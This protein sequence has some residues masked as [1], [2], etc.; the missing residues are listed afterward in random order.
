MPP[1]SL[2][3]PATSSP[4][5]GPPARLGILASGSGS[6]FAA[7]QQAI[8]AQQLNAEIRC[9]LYNIADAH[10]AKRARAHNIPAIFIDHKAYKTRLAFDTA[11][12]QQL[13]QHD[14]EWLL[15]AGW[16]RRLTTTFID[17]YPN[18]IL[19]IHPS[20]LPSFPGLHAVEQ[21]LA[22][23][24]TISGCTVHIVT[25]ELDSGPILA[26]AA[27]PVLRDDTTQTLHARIQHQEHHLY[28]HALN[29]ALSRRYFPY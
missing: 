28:P 24:V 1:K 18:K 9:V 17:A 21:A 25:A 11:L 5:P 2:V 10:V 14:I 4:Q 13:L 22:A 8:L 26:Q 6:N 16:M 27:V 7:I 29:L 3:S 20:L 23:G 19:N 12:L 15:L